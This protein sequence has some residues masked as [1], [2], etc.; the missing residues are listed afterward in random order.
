MASM[1]K[2]APEDLLWLKDLEKK[3]KKWTRDFNPYV[4]DLYKDYKII[5]HGCHVQSNGELGYE[6]AEGVDRHVVSLVRKKCTCR[7]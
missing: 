4:M 6:V 1:S 7:T 3:G 5:A 2:Q